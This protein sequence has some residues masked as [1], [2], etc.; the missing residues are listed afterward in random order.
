MT[1]LAIALLPTLPPLALG[2]VLVYGVV[3]LPLA[4]RAGDRAGTAAIVSEAGDA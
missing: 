3:V 4:N 2:L 1:R